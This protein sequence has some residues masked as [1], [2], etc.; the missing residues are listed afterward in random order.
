LELG[1]PVDIAFW[2]DLLAELEAA[3]G[4]PESAAR[5]FGGAASLRTEVGHT[6]GEND[7]IS[8]IRSAL[9]EPSFVAAWTRG[10]TLGRARLVAEARGVLAERLPRS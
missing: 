7:A 1:D 3:A 5:F 10:Q 2:L 9:G 8:D 6:H 4:R